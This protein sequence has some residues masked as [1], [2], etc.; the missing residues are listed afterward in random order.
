MEEFSHGDTVGIRSDTVKTVRGFYV[1]SSF[2]PG[3]AYMF[4]KI[5]MGK[6]DFLLDASYVRVRKK[7]LYSH[8]MLLTE[9]IKKERR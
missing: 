6:S 3:Y 4:P 8:R 2:S 5:V 9:L 7:S 1:G